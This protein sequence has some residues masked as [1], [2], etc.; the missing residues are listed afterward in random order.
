MTS[1]KLNKK[2]NS[3][4]VFALKRAKKA[5]LFRFVVGLFC[6]RLQLTKLTLKMCLYN[7]IL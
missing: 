4:L 6:G 1:H 2:L 3:C 5:Y 7:E